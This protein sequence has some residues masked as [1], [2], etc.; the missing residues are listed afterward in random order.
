M[1]FITT[2]K[3]KRKTSVTYTKVKG[4]QDQLDEKE[5]GGV[6]GESGDFYIEPWI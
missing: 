1:T 2:Y 3:E 5:P 6:E 4:A